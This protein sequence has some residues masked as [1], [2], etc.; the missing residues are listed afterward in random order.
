MIFQVGQKPPVILKLPYG[1][2]ST[3]K[4]KGY[5]PLTQ[6]YQAIYRGFIPPCITA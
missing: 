1:Y 5:N 2:N 3:S 6:L 4:A